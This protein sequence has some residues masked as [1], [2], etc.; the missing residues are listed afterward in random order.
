M[1]KEVQLLFGILGGTAV[2]ALS[3]R[4]FDNFFPTIIMTMVGAL[5]S[6]CTTLLVQEAVAWYK[7]RRKQ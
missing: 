5:V 1:I 4:G 3:Q 2:A 6:C 7:K